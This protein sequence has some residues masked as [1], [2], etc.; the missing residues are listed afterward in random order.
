MRKEDCLKWACSFF[1]AKLLKTAGKK[2][3][4]YNELSRCIQA[5]PHWK[6]LKR[7]WS[8]TAQL[9]VL[10]FRVWSYFI[11]P[12]CFHFVLNKLI[13]SVSVMWNYYQKH[14]YLVLRFNYGETDFV[15]INLSGN[16]ISLRLKCSSECWILMDCSFLPAVN[17][18]SFEQILEYTKLKAFVDDL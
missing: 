4:E 16:I 5:N 14:R 18:L 7:D 9:S 12:V 2:L 10:M 17:W 11:A 8:H 3:K 6:G 15:K 13:L 1:P